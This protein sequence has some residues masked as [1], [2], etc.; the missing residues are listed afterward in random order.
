MLSLDIALG[1][2]RRKVKSPDVLARSLDLKREPEAGVEMA[3]T[4]G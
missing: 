3:F 1:G 4:Q 2:H